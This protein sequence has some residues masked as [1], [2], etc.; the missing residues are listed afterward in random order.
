MS[1]LAECL[2]CNHQAQ[3]PDR[4]LG[5]SGRCPKCRNWYTLVP[6]PNPPRAT[7]PPT[8]LPL[9]A[10]LPAEAA[11]AA[12]PSPSVS[13]TKTAGEAAGIGALPRLERLVAPQ[14]PA[15][16][17]SPPP[18][19][20]RIDPLGL[21]ALLL[22]AAALWCASGSRLAGLVVPL[23]LLGLLAGLVAVLLAR[24]SG[25]S[26][27]LFPVAGAVVAGGVIFTALTLPGLLG[28][29]FQASRARD[30]V[31]PT[32]L[33]VV[34]FPGQGTT[35]DL[36]G[37]EWVDASRAS[38]QQGRVRLQV[39][40]AWVAPAEAPA[41]PPK[42]VAPEEVL[43]LRLRAHLV[44]D[45][46][47]FAADPLAPPAGGTS[48][49]PSLTDDTGKV[50]AARTIPDGEA[51]ED[52]N[53]SSI[54][55]VAVVE[56]VFAFEPASPTVRYLRLEV[57]AGVW[58]ASGAFRFTIPAAMILRDPAAPPRDGRPDK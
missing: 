17:V 32:A 40:R 8:A 25:R 7:S 10:P 47:A 16:P 43:L 5:A 30:P 51:A 37:P 58:G 15:K 18:A 1:F 49:R 53:P 41:A 22:G 45:A 24:A 33:R 2:F 44:E 34:P 21:G 11:P 27:L 3:V 31:D 29:A 19:P 46:R 52:V 57:P 39:V 20:R 54:F 6:T 14:V 23:S 35:G 36:G 4:A 42:Q 56:N 38:L 12:A 28:P 55:P 13:A 26:R 50:Y 48:Y 9:P